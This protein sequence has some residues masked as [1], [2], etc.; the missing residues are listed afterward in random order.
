MNSIKLLD[1]SCP[2]YLSIIISTFN[3][4]ELLRQTLNS[5]AA[6]G[7]ISSEILIIDG[8]SN[9]G[10]DRVISEFSHVVSHYISAWN[11]GLCLSKGSYISFLGAGDYY[12]DDGL[13]RLIDFSFANK[14]A[15]LILSNVNLVKKD[16]FVRQL[17][18]D[19]SWKIFRRNMNIAHVGSFHSRRLFNSYGMFDVSYRIAGDYEF[20]L[21]SRDS[22]K[23]VYLD[24][25]TVQMEAGGVSQIN[26]LVFI[27]SEHAKIKHKS[28]SPFLARLDTYV[29][30]IKHNIRRIL[31]F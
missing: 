15:D 6:C 28:V 26:P 31:F 4:A 1:G 27:E 9:D 10:T 13:Q 5:L 18:C 25:V 23:T 24:R 29:S 19:W 20:L 2:I 7:V 8:G 21:R 11:K 16:R 12:I 14:D 30:R 3:D 22:L 17:G